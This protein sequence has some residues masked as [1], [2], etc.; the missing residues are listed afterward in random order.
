MARRLP[1]KICTTQASRFKSWLL[2]GWTRRGPD[3]RRGRTTEPPDFISTMRFFRAPLRSP[4]V[5]TTRDDRYFE[6]MA[7]SI[8]VCAKYKPKFGTSGSKGLSRDE[9]ERAYGDDP[10]YHWVGMDSPL[11]YAAHKAAGGLTSVYRQ[12]GKGGEKLFRQVVQDEL[13]LSAEQAIWKYETEKAGGGKRE[14]Q[15]DARIE[16]AHV[17]SREKRKR[18]TGWMRDAADEL[19]TAPEFKKGLKGAVFEVRQGYKSA[20]SKR[21]NADLGNAATALKNM[22]VPCLVL[23]ST[24]INRTVVDRYSASWLVLTGTEAGSTTE[25]CYVFSR[26]VLGYDLAGFFKRK[27][28]DF[29]ALLESTLSQLLKTEDG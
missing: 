11:L 5:T 14:L 2:R 7:E 29:R 17:A 12:L 21:Q 25:S 4:C 13:G 10:F 23:L 15:L 1:V 8:R 19:A 22:Y 20:D 28:E 26:D 27:S 6:L 16:Y 9:F 24:Q 18:V 3:H